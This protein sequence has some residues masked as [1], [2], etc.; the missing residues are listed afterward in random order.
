VLNRNQHVVLDG[1]TRPLRRPIT[2]P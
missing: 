1:R 2:A